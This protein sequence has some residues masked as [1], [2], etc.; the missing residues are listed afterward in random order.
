MLS[1]REFDELGGDVNLI[2]RVVD[3]LSA[4]AAH[5]VFVPAVAI[6]LVLLARVSEV[7]TVSNEFDSS[8][9]LQT[10]CAA[11]FGSLQRV[12]TSDRPSSF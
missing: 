5:I 12:S 6:E 4:A 7:Y 1:A 8:M 11:R 3:R 9:A 10:Y 2:R